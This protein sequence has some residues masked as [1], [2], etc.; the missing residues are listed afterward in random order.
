MTHHVDPGLAVDSQQVSTLLLVQGGESALWVDDVD[1]CRRREVTQIHPGGRRRSRGEPISAALVCW[2]DTTWRRAG[3]RVVDRTKAQGR[4]D[5]KGGVL[6]RELLIGVLGRGVLVSVSPVTDRLDDDPVDP[7]SIAGRC[8]TE[9]LHI[10]ADRLRLQLHETV[11][12]ALV[13]DELV[14]GQHGSETQSRP[15]DFGSGARPLHVVHVFQPLIQQMGRVRCGAAG[16]GFTPR[17]D[18]AQF[19]V[20]HVPGDQHIAE[21]LLRVDPKRDPHSNDCPRRPGLDRILCRQL[22]LTRALPAHPM[23][24]PHLSVNAQQV[25]GD[26]GTGLDQWR[27]LWVELMQHR[28]SLVLVERQQN[29]HRQIACR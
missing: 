22:G 5:H 13:V 17:S 26:A 9:T 29:D 19:V 27:V 16:D 12:K 8:E 4:M 10:P 15:P 28:S 7:V 14:A 21:L 18:P 2:R 11:P 6:S 1:L 24:D 25:V 20:A 3:Q 23:H